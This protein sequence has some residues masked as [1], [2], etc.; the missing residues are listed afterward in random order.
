MGNQL[1]VSLTPPSEVR[2]NEDS[3]ATWGWAASTI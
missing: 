2:H 3:S 1:K